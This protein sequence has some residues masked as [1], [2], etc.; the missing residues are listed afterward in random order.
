[1][2]T[3]LSNK[4]RMYSFSGIKEET[5]KI[6]IKISPSV[7]CVSNQSGYI[8]SKEQ[9]MYI[10]GNNIHNELMTKINNPVIPFIHNISI[11]SAVDVEAKGNL[12]FYL[13]G[14]GKAY[15]QKS[16]RMCLVKLGKIQIS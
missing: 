13:D 6:D 11:H 3:I 12:Q 4:D 14:E 9:K 5:E 16:E 1:M 15:E 10:W 7:I 8:V 2:T